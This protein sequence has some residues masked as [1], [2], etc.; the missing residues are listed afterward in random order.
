PSAVRIPPKV[1][2]IFPEAS[3]FGIIIPQIIACISFPLLN[4]SFC[5]PMAVLAGMIS[6]PRLKAEG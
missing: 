2:L 6:P 3:P 1:P 5:T 4:F